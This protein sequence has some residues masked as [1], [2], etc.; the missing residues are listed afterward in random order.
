MDTP[1]Y[2]VEFSAKSAADQE[3]HYEKV[4]ASLGEEG[5]ALLQ[6]MFALTREVE[7]KTGWFRPE[8]S[9]LPKEK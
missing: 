4:I 6:K 9:Y 1:A 2:I 8:L 5:M 7:L 3:T